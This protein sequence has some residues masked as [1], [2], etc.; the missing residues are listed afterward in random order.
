[1]SLINY[2]KK[3]LE[4]P[5]AEGQ[6]NMTAST[7][8]EL[9]MIFELTGELQQRIDRQAGKFPQTDSGN[10]ELIA[11]LGRDLYKFDHRHGLWL[12]FSG[13]YWRPDP[14]DGMIRFAKAAA[15][16]RY[17]RAELIDDL[18]ERALE[19][20][21]AISS[22]SRHRIDAALRMARSEEGI[23]DAGNNWNRDPF[24]FAVPN[25][26]IDLHTGK[27]RE[28]KPEDN[29]NLHSPI[30]YDPKA[31][32][33]RWYQFL[34]EVFEGDSAIID[35]IQ[36]RA[37][38]SAT[39]ETSEQE[40]AILIG[41]GSNGK[42]VFLRMIGAAL[43]DYSY[44]MPFSTIE[45][46]ERS[47]IPNDLAA[48]VDRR[49]VTAAETNQGTRLNEARIKALTGCDPITARFLH[50]EFFTFYPVAKFWLCVNHRPRVSD[51]S[52]GFWRRV[53]LINFNRQFTGKDA[54]PDLEKK[55]RAELPG[56]L[57][58][59]VRGCLRWQRVGLKPPASVLNATEDYQHESDP[60]AEFLT[61]RCIEDPNAEEG[62]GSL[63]QRYKEW[64]T[65]R[66]LNV[67]EVLGSK[68]F[69]ELIA[70]RFT[71]IRYNSGNRYRGIRI[72]GV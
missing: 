42:T 56:I 28:G 25:G 8:S 67:R 27:L 52:F 15:R 13:S 59:I 34:R 12:K 1:M 46:K 9:E 18:K 14:D 63:Y 2:S 50:A 41:K 38:Y 21:F 32:C 17:Q 66:K 30:K 69:G 68:T 26:V 54:D 55:L 16:I 43:G 60:L 23:A 35:F 44:N 65:D 36:R 11:S 24:L 22:E 29:I 19:S 48:L 61:E 31:R 70:E 4:K 47:A 20:Q 51:Q 49:F 53:R 64:A 45:L 39:G 33:R 7:L 72:L 62:A 5:T 37:G 71:K 3:F 40:I 10:G 57:A 6:H 58:W